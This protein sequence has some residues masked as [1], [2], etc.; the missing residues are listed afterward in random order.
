MR[1]GPRSE[2]ASWPAPSRAC[3]RTSLVWNYVVGNY[4]KGRRRRL[5]ILLYW[6]GDSANLPGPM[7]FHTCAICIST[8]GLREPGALVMCGQAVDLSRVPIPTYLLARTT[9]ISFRGDRRTRRVGFLGATLASCLGGS[10]HIAGVIIRRRSVRRNFWTNE[11]LTDDATIGLIGRRNTGA[12]AGGRTGRH[13][14][15]NTADR[16]ALA[17]TRAGSDAHPSLAPAP[18]KYRFRAS[19]LKRAVLVSRAKIS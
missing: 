10:G 7:Y 3:G 5:S 16:G 6:N 19:R 18:G 2:A 17:P 9:I 13:G 1:R 15:R 11:L 8:T 12:E 14:C 4:L